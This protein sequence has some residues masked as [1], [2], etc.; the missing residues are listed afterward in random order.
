[1]AT[2][3][4]TT[5]EAVGF[6]W[7]IVKTHFWLLVGIV[8]IMLFLP[9]PFRLIGNEFKNAG[10]N[11]ASTAFIFSLAAFVL[12]IILQLGVFRVCLA[13][14]RGSTPKVSDLFKEYNFFFK[15]LGASILYGLI[16]VGGLILLIVPGVIWSIKFSMYGYFIIDKNVG[17]IEALKMSADLTAGSKGKLF[18]LNL[19]LVGIN[20]LG[21]LALGV[22]VIIT[23]GM[24]LVVGAWVYN[25]LLNTSDVV[26]VPTPLVPPTPIEPVV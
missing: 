1:M 26:P 12:D 15:Y 14:V 24:S 19:T 8:L 22:G 13:F 20:I 7:G 21:L 23:A 9:L 17:P 2:L 18:L 5:N 3:K 4:F 25:R 6:S 10:G 11:F 16:V